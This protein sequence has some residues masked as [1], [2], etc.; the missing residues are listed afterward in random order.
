[1]L[2]LY[3]RY[4]D[5]ILAV[6]PANRLLALDVLRALGREANALPAVRAELDPARGVLP[7]YD[8]ALDAW[9]ALSQDSA[10][11][12]PRARQAAA[13]LA[14]LWQAAL[15]IRHAPPPVAAAFVASRLGQGA[16]LVGE[17]PGGHDAGEALARAWPGLG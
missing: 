7:G 12:E 5:A 3:R 13:G 16:V 17:W 11:A 15:L 1:M 4:A 10:N 2:S 8:R 14:R 6:L 9:L